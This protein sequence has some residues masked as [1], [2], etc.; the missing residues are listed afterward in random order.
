MAFKI[1]SSAVSDGQK[2]EKWRTLSLMTTTGWCT[3]NGEASNFGET[4]LEFLLNEPC[5]APR[6]LK[7][8]CRLKPEPD[9]DLPPFT[10]R[11][12]PS[13]LLCLPDVEADGCPGR[14]KAFSFWSS[15]ASLTMPLR[16]VRPKRR[17][18]SFGLNRV[19]SANSD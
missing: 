17:A 11:D 15:E 16:K 18:H 10:A 5:L 14:P 4:N 2:D 12:A 6:L 7:L 8:P 9:P 3:Y 19:D 1:Q 13:L